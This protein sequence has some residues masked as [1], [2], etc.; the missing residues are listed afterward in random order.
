MPLL[1]GTYLISVTATTRNGGHVYDGRDLR[2]RFE[3]MQPGRQRGRV[4]LEPKVVHFYHDPTLAPAGGE[5]A[6]ATGA[7]S[8]DSP[9]GSA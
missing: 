9:A 7:E 4:A 6:G 5:A 2:D 1:D 3:V 8:S